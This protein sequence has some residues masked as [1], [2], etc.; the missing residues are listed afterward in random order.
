MKSRE[1]QMGQPTDQYGPG[2]DTGPNAEQASR[3]S[4]LKATATKIGPVVRDCLSDYFASLGLLMTDEAGGE[5]PALFQE[6]DGPQGHM[7]QASS[8]KK[9]GSHS[10]YRADGVHLLDEHTAYTITVFLVVDKNGVPLLHIGKYIRSKLMG[11]TP[12]IASEFQL[13]TPAP[14]VQALAAKTG[15][16]MVGPAEYQA[17]RI[18]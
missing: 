18:S 10:D 6:A 11:G 16:K 4:V 8:R 7:W 1:F 12:V 9:T 17:A 13:E 3:L 5:H 14:L 15:C 2:K